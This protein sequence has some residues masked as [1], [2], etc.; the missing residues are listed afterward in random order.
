MYFISEHTIVIQEF[1]IYYCRYLFQSNL[2]VVLDNISNTSASILDSSTP[3]KYSTE[4]HIACEY[5]L[6]HASTKRMASTEF[7]LEQMD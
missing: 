5:A 1:C 6:L 3:T 2:A 4:G 7:A